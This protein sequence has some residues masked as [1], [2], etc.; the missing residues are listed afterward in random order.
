MGSCDQ[1]ERSKRVST[2]RSLAA[3]PVAV[4]QPHPCLSLNRDE[5]EVLCKLFPDL[6]SAN[7]HPG[8]GVSQ[9]G[10]FS[11]RSLPRLEKQ[12]DELLTLSAATAIDSAPDH[13]FAEG[14]GRR[15]RRQA[16]P[17]ART[18]R[19]SLLLSQERDEMVSKSVLFSSSLFPIIL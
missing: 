16:E 3:T 4:P 17:L 19:T 2:W 15:L 12:P 7:Y 6:C 14:L 1:R 18:R 10:S 11:S 8:C 5:V 13:V 9:P